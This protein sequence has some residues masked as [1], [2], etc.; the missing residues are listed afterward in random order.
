MARPAPSTAIVGDSSLNGGRGF[1]AENAEDCRRTQRKARP[2]GSASL[3]H[4]L[5]SSAFSA[6]RASDVGRLIMGLWRVKGR[7]ARSIQPQDA[8]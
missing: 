3:A 7:N 4:S 8:G 1:N 6:S 5:F 2:D